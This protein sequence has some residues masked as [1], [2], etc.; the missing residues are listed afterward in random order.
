[1][2]SVRRRGLTLERSSGAARVGGARFPF[3][4]TARRPYR[5]R[6]TTA[7]GDRRSRSPCEPHRAG[8]PARA[9]PGRLA[10]CTEELAPEESATGVGGRDDCGRT[11]ESVDRERR[12]T[13][14]RT[15]ETRTSAL[16][17]R[18]LARFARTVVIL[19][20]QPLGISYCRCTDGPVLAAN[21]AVVRRW[22]FFARNP[23]GTRSTAGIARSRAFRSAARVQTVRARPSLCG[24]LEERDAP[25]NA[26]AATLSNASD[27]TSARVVKSRGF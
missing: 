25:L 17:S 15:R 10:S 27:W 20:S 19:K 22:F 14:R 2:P 13:P 1:M 11:F 4:L 9:T 6:A 21:G 24:V 16:K 8:I 18:A 26:E 5:T 12:S 3:N 23:W 7:G